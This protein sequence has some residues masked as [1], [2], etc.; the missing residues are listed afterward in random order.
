MESRTREL[1]HLLS[2]LNRRGGFS[3]AV[4]T[5]AQGLP[6]AAASGAGGRAEAQ[7]AVLAL[8]QRTA[9]Q[10]GD[11]LGMAATDEVALFDEDGRRLVCRPF[12]VDDRRMI[13][14]VMVPDR[15]RAYRRLT[16]EALRSAATILKGARE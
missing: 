14:G 16:S 8:V 2:E 13:L 11:R 15:R 3:A 6:I 5:D 9:R 12:T 4:L 1:Q 7:A 10:V